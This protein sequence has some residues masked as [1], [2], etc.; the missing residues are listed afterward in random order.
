MDILEADYNLI[1]METKNKKV[2]GVGIEDKELTVVIKCLRCGKVDEYK[3]DLDKTKYLKCRDCN[4]TEY[5]IPKIE[6]LGDIGIVK[7][8]ILSKHRYKEYK[9]KDEEDWL[10]LFS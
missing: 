7:F 10:K 5:L 3:I 4:Y 1:G 8:G 2:I 9:R 6:D